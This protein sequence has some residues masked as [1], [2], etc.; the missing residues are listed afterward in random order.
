MSPKRKSRLICRV[1]L[2][3]HHYPEH[4]SGV[5]I[6]AGHLA[7]VLSS[8]GCHIAWAASSNAASDRS[9]DNAIIRIAM[10]TWNVAERRL[11]FCYPLWGPIS[12]CQLFRQ[13]CE[14]DL[15][16]LHEY[17]YPGN[18]FAFVIAKLLRKPIVV[19]Q[20]ANTIPYKSAVM[21]YL[22]EFANRTFG[23]LML[24]NA[25]HCCF[26][27]AKAMAYFSR[28]FPLGRR[29]EFVPNGVDTTLFHP[30]AA[31][32]RARV[33]SGLKWADDQLVALFV[34]RF[35][36][37]KRLDLMHVLAQAFPRIRWVFVGSGPKCPARW[38]LPNVDPMGSIPQRE[39]ARLYQAADLF[40]LPSVG[41]GFPLVVQESMACGTP[42]LITHDT[43]RGA[44]GVEGLS[45]TAEATADSLIQAVQ[46]I[47]ERPD[48]LR[49]RRSAVARFARDQWSWQRCGERYVTIFQQLTSPAD[50][51]GSATDG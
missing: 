37:L 23:R 36:E 33:R 9:G 42:V 18:I 38:R 3:T 17:I 43:A 20:H 32:E 40:V 2:V 10:S 12:I 24:A 44:P 48:R 11:G 16:H 6:A 39:I 49:E 22:L 4:R 25:S 19:T 51:V 29:S 50:T 15:L 1:L 41:E 5:A 26:I 34:G 30:L 46:S 7:D 13:V 8:S 28:I 21:R 47:V 14:C 31:D 45:F 27:S 35:V